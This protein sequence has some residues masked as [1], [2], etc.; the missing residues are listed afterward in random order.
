[1]EAEC[2]SGP[3]L[4]TCAGGLENVLLQEVSSEGVKLLPQ[5]GLLAKCNTQRSLVLYLEPPCLLSRT[6]WILRR[7]ANKASPGA[8][9]LLTSELH[10]QSFD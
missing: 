2:F 10:Y 1:M 7:L 4:V 8:G 6:H 5:S 9:N 3:Y